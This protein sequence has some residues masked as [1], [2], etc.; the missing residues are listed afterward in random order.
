MGLLSFMI[1]PPHT[2]APIV[3]FFSILIFVIILGKFAFAI[4]SFIGRI[5]GMRSPRIRKVFNGIGVFVSILTICCVLYS[6]LYG[7]RNYKVRQITIYSKELPVAFDGYRIV[8]FSDLHIGA[9]NSRTDKNV[10]HIVDLINRQRANL[11]VFTGDLINISTN[12]LNGF[13]PALAQ[14]KAPDG[15]Y[16]ILGNHDYGKYRRWKTEKEEEDNL[17][18]LKQKEKE[19]GWHLLLNEHV[20]LHRNHSDI[21]LIGT[22]DYGDKVSYRFGDLKKSM[23]GLPNNGRGIYKIMLAH[24]PTFWHLKVLPESD[25]Q[26]TLSGHTHGM[27]FKIGSF[28]PCQW[29]FTEWDGLYAV[30]RRILNVNLGVGALMS[31]RFGAWPEITVITLRR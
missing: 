1:N 31:F 5:I 23:S 20:L 9:F 25:I 3:R 29:L 18:L 15:I 28:S 21:A 14:L 10:R 16:S 13:E 19:I 11:I 17:S 12:E 6:F 2:G 30:G 8:Q 26:L 4:V 22:E 7:Y 24:D 27:Q